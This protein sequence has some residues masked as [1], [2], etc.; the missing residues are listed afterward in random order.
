VP[1]GILG[2]IGGLLLIYAIYLPYSQGFVLAAHIN[3]LLI[4]LSLAGSL[5]Y[6]IRSNTWK[7]LSLSKSIDS[8]VREDYSTQVK[9]GDK[10]QAVS[11]LTPM[12]KARFDNLHLEVKSYTGFV[13]QGTE[14]EIVEIEQDR[15]I[16]KPLK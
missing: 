15:I 7:K 14:I 10:G 9:V 16:V 5:F 12:G 2:V 4:V 3:V 6:A 8:K 1:G 11:R 13:D